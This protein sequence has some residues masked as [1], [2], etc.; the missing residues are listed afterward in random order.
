MRNRIEFYKEF[1]P[2]HWE[3]E[4][5]TRGCSKFLFRCEREKKDILQLTESSLGRNCLQSSKRFVR[6]HLGISRIDH[7]PP[8]VQSHWEIYPI[9]LEH[10]GRLNRSFVYATQEFICLTVFTSYS[11]RKDFHLMRNRMNFSLTPCTWRG[12]KSH[13]VSQNVKNKQIQEKRSPEKE[14]SSLFAFTC[15]EKRF[16][17]VV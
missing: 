16:Y 13:Q 3:K 7:F 2:V 1:F 11:L 6:S 12:E 9:A 15:R 17:T 4:G 14:Q 10:S 5:E 8:S